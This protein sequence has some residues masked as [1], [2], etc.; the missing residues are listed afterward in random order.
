MNFN[1]DLGQLFTN[2]MGFLSKLNDLKFCHI[3]SFFHKYKDHI[4]LSALFISLFTTYKLLKFRNK[5]IDNV[6]NLSPG[7]I[8]TLEGKV[9]IYNN[10]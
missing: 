3:I 9:I 4:S 5:N 6:R 7:R 1:V 8:Y 10:I 2:L